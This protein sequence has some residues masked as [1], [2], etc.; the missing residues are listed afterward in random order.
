[1]ADSALTRDSKG[2]FASGN[3]GGPGRPPALKEEQYSEIMRRTVDPQRWREAIE[4]V[5]KKAQEGDLRAFEVLAKHLLPLPAQRL[6]ISDEPQEEFRVAGLPPG[7]LGESMLNRLIKKV[8]ERRAYE[9]SVE[10]DRVKAIAPAAQ[11]GKPNGMPI[12]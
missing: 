5:L 1:M 6:K 11:P 10:A 3:A 8:L 2:Q 12:R 4:A 9:K 7:E